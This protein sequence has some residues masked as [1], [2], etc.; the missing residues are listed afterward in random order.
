[1][2][3][4]FLTNEGRK[5]LQEQL[6]FLSS[7]EK[8]RILEELTDARE[9]GSIDEN[10][11]Y[12]V[13][14]DEYSKLLLKIEKLQ[15]KLRNSVLITS[16]DVVKDRVSILSS[17][18]VLNI[19]SNKE[20]TFIIVPENEINIRSGKISPDSPIGSGLLGRNIGD[21]CKINTPGGLLELQILKISI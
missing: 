16:E 13:A 10:T 7:N 2:A 19:N 4:V 20:M 6:D 11:E 12:M 3:K 15:D 21:I 9:R 14:K 8:F 17:V 1:M 5:K 18:T